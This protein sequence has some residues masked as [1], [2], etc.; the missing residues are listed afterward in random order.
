MVGQNYKMLI[1]FST[2]VE[3]LKS[4]IS[5]NLMF[6]TSLWRL[7]ADFLLAKATRVNHTASN[8]VGRR[9]IVAL[10]D[11]RIYCVKRQMQHL[12]SLSYVLLIRIIASIKWYRFSKYSVKK[13]ILDRLSMAKTNETV[14]SCISFDFIS[15]KR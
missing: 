3:K 10:C 12:E 11:V 8:R 6:C 2:N 14:I 1:K 4:G 9:D 15:K 7:G 13:E 5:R